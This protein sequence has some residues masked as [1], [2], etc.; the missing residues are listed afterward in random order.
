VDEAW[1]G[2]NLKFIFRRAIDR[3]L[4]EMWEELKQIVSSIQKTDEEDAIFGN[5]THQEGI[6]FSPYM[7]SLMI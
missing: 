4:M 6:L 1:Y 5:S 2:V 3:E 7:L